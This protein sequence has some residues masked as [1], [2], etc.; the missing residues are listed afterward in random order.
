MSHGQG[1]T[2]DTLGIWSSIP[3]EW[4]TDPASDSAFVR[5]RMRGK[6]VPQ[7][8]PLDSLENHHFSSSL[9][10]WRMI[11]YYCWVLLGQLTFY[12]PALP[13][14]TDG[15]NSIMREGQ[16]VLFFKTQRFVI[17]WAV[18]D[19]QNYDR[20]VMVMECSDGTSSHIQHLPST[21]TVHYLFQFSKYLK[22]L[23]T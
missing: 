14:K 16:Y 11:C 6:P 18:L 12:W 13:I 2:G 22:N 7:G 4:L 8:S 23:S 1:L 17:C 15:C 3:D 20:E 5:F 19:S 9:W 10:D 21:V